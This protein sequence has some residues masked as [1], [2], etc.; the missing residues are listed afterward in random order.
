MCCADADIETLFR[1]G[2]ALTCQ[3]CAHRLVMVAAEDDEVAR[4]PICRTC[5]QMSPNEMPFV[6]IFIGTAS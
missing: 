1:C 4:C 2:H 6:R 5:L 3:A